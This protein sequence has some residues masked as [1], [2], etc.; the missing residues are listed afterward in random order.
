M[1]RKNYTKQAR[2]AMINVGSI[3]NISA[4]RVGSMSYTIKEGNYEKLGVQVKDDEIIF[5]FEG[6]KEDN[7]AIL[8]YGKKHE[9]VERIEVP[10]A[11][12]MGSIRSLSVKGISSGYLRYNYE[13]NGDITVD[14][15]ASKIIGREKWNDS[16]RAACDYRV[17]GGVESQEFD[18]GSDHCPEVPRHSMIMYKLHV[19]GFSMDAGIRGKTKGTFAAIR[20][21]IPYLKKLGITT[22]ELMPVYEFEELMFHEEPELPDYINWVT[23]EEDLIQPKEETVT[24][25]DK[26]NY[27]G[28]VP[29]NYFAVKSSYSSTPNASQEFKELIRA[30]HANGMECVMEMCFDER[31]NQNVILDALRFWVREYHVDGFH[32]LGSSV[33]VTAVA[34]DMFLSRTKIFYD[35]FEPLL[36]EQKRK[37]PHLFAYNDEYLYPARK[38][39]NQMNGSLE[40][41]VCQQRKQHPMQG[42][43]NYIA[44]S[45]GFTLMDVFSYSEKHNEA[46][47]EDNCDGINWNFSTNCG[48]EGRSSKRFVL[49]LREQRLRNAIAI[50]MLGQGVPLL[51]AGDEMGN[52]QEGNNNAYCQDNRT[53]WLN[54]SKGAKFEWLRTYIEQMIAFRQAHPVI[55]LDEPMRMN[56]YARKGLPDLSYHG[57][58]AW[59]SAFPEDRRS[60]GMMYCGA[61]AKREDGTED[62][63][64]YVGYNFHNWISR[65]ALPKLPAKKSWYLIMDTS[66][67]KDAFLPVEEEVK[68][69]QMTVKGQSVVILLGK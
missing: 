14:T 56:D 10:A 36:L 68:G 6:E 3:M 39:L 25:L 69:Q 5:T 47:G 21:R 55:T 22:V 1:N 11:Y 64:V 67:G 46:N 51:H 43:V 31:M 38:M 18:W 33:P 52:S 35:Q 19:R 45:N 50:L 58:N 9:L 37:Y 62:D 30:L 63:F 42:F 27:W 57:E 4:E 60:V 53:G 8:L 61:Y 23:L 49:E 41:F 66:L 65:L 26:I 40:E 28:Y 15:Y 54:W 12:C 59:I 32:L 2:N 17:Y 20:E 16:A 13:I 34:Q 48:V 29:G 44:G 7:C 24:K